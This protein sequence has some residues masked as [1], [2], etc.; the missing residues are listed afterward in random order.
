MRKKGE[1]QNGCFKKTK[2]IKFPEISEEFYE[3]SKN[4]FFTEHLWTAAFFY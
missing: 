2:H 1:T 4:T 3:I